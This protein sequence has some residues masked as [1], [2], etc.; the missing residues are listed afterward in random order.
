MAIRLAGRGRVSKRRLSAESGLLG[1]AALCVALV[2]GCDGQDTG[3]RAISDAS[4]Q[5]RTVSPGSV[6]PTSDEFATSRLRATAGKLDAVNREGSPAQKAIAA[7]LSA[8]VE[9]GMSIP[10]LSR[11]VEVEHEIGMKLTR[12]TSLETARVTAQQT[13]SAL[14]A[15]DA[16]VERAS[17]DA[18]SRALQGDLAT[19]RRQREQLEQQ[20]Q[21]LTGQISALESRVSSIRAEESAMRD[22][23][24]REGPIE[25]AETIEQARLTSRQA[26]ALEVQAS[27]LDAQRSA[28]GPQIEAQRVRIEAIDAQLAMLSTAREG[29][30]TQARQTDAEA[31][32]AERAASE[33]AAQI[34]ALATEVGVL[35]QN[36]AQAAL[37]SAR[38][39]LDKAVS[40]A[41]RATDKDADGTLASARALGTLG[42]VQAWR[43]S[44]LEHTA[45]SFRGI[46]ERATGEQTR[47]L[48]TLADQLSQMADGLKQDAIVSYEQAVTGLRRVRATGQTR[49]SLNLA[50]DNLERAIE[51]LG[52]KR[53][54]QAEEVDADYPG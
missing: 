38:Q 52:G 11:L 29:V 37:D 2:P 26:D 50:A 14:R 44:S 13:A 9:T 12:I 48:S 32:Q 17:L 27:T 42:D 8:E 40:A 18:R 3:A 39:S 43:A 25:A 22:R 20:A 1:L 19:A 24:L 28:L 33:H 47:R 53:P 5:L 35:H 4:I 41:R 49:E 10:S 31:A 54:S 15:F 46:A 45:R 34:V 30:E 7:I 6:P 51:R 16:T 23:A 21:A 36:E